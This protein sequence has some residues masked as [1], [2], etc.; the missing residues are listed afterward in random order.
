MDALLKHVSSTPSSRAFLS[1]ATT[2]DP[3]D[4]EDEAAPLLT[5]ELMANTP[6]WPIIH[7]IKADVMVSP[8]VPLSSSSHVPLALHR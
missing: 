1:R 2:M 3:R 4:V 8:L 5:S 7:E 6:V